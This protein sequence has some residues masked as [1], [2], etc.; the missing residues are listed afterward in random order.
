VQVLHSMTIM[1]PKWGHKTQKRLQTFINTLTQYSPRL[2]CHNVYNKTDSWENA[3]SR[4]TFSSLF[5][6]C[7]ID[8][9]A[10]NVVAFITIFYFGNKRSASAKS[11]E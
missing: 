5:T 6:V 3:S 4:I 11:G 10:F 2:L 8:E 7:W 1:F 9:T